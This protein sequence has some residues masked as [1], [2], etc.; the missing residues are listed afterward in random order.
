MDDEYYEI[1]TLEDSSESFERLKKYA[2]KA[3]VTFTNWRFEQMPFDKFILYKL[4]VSKGGA[5]ISVSI[6]VVQ[7]EV[8][9][10][11]VY[12]ENTKLETEDVNKMVEIKLDYF[13]SQTIDKL[14]KFFDEHT[15]VK[16]KTTFW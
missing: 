16:G 4:D 10:V 7:K 11:S 6:E 13:T 8:L 15:C 9:E 1:E 2:Q 14:L 5:R 3:P 12:A